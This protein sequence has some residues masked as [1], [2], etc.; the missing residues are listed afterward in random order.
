MIV[1]LSVIGLKPWCINTEGGLGAAGSTMVQQLGAII[2]WC[3]VTAY[4]TIT[5]FLPL[6][7]NSKFCD[8]GGP[9]S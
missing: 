4:T 8:G 6:L 1:P 5:R 7:R 2:S 3:S 9:L